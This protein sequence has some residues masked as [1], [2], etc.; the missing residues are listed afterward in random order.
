MNDD[1]DDTSKGSAS[2]GLNQ[3]R[4][5][6]EN[7]N[8]LLDRDSTDE[9]RQEWTELLMQEKVT[10]TSETLSV[11]IFRLGVEWFALSTMV[12][13]EVYEQR[14]VHRLPHRS[15]DIF[16]GLVNIRGRLRL[17]ASLHS[18]LDIEETPEHADGGGYDRMVVIDKEGE[19]WVFPVDEV[20]GI[21]HFDPVTVTNVP[22]TISKSSA[23][24]LQG[25]LV[26]DGQSVGYIDE[27]LLFSSLARNVL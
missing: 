5:C 22:V 17:C 14:P 2:K 11:L 4:Y 9:Y 25:M 21:Q 23:N 26:H 1:R 19:R 8:R 3:P 10:E 20:V 6:V 16:S 18:L 27:N 7:A 12:M 13:R 24:Y 15:S